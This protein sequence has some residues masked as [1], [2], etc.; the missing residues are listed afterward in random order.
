MREKLIINTKTWLHREGGGVSILLRKGD[1]QRCCLGIYLQD[2]C[3]VSPDVLRGISSP[4]LLPV[5]LRDTLPDWL[6]GRD[7]FNTVITED[8][9]SANDRTD[10]TEADVRE[11]IRRLFAKVEVEVIYADGVDKE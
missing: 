11:E 5:S 6:M 1:G 9:M 2:N 7:R 4:D 3:G 10:S 8:L